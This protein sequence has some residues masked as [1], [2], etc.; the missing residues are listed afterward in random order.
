MLS[1]TLTGSDDVYEFLWRPHLVGLRRAQK[2]G[3]RKG[4]RKGLSEGGHC[5]QISARGL[6]YTSGYS[7]PGGRRR[8]LELGRNK[9]KAEA[10]LA[11]MVSCEKRGQ[12]GDVFGP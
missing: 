10:G 4:S 3:S 5:I 7:L 1:F 12:E 2:E 9:S 11:K 6:T 8:I